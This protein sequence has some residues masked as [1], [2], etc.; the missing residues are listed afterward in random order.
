MDHE[1][2]KLF[3][4]HKERYRIWNSHYSDYLHNE[5]IWEE[6]AE[7]IKQTGSRYYRAFNSIGL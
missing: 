2:L 5:K 6:I 4:E 1:K 7:E 3:R